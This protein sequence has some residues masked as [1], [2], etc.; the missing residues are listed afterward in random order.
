MADNK[1]KIICEFEEKLLTELVKRYRN[2]KKDAGTNTLNYKTGFDPEKIFPGYHANNTNSQ[3]VAAFNEAAEK[4]QSAGYV[5]L[6]FRPR[7]NEIDEIRLVDARVDD[8]ENYLCEAYG[9]VR[10]SEQMQRARQIVVK[11]GNKTV[12]AAAAECAKIS[13]KL[14][15]NRVPT[16]LDKIE[17]EVRALSFIEEN[18]KEL[19]LRELAGSVFGDSKALDDT[20][21]GK[22]HSDLERVCTTLRKHYNRPCGEDEANI[23]ILEDFHIMAEDTQLCIKGD[24]VIVTDSG[25]IHAGS[26]P[27]GICLFASDFPKIIRIEVN[28]PYFVT[29]ENLTSW[30]RMEKRNM[31]FFY[32]GGFVNRHRREFLKKVY[33]DNPNTQYLHF[34]DIDVGGFRIHADLCRKTGIPFGLYKMSVEEL[35]DERNTGWLH[36]LTD[37]DRAMLEKLLDV[38]EYAQTVW[39]MLQHNVK[40]EQEAVS[41]VECLP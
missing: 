21:K 7:S 13:E 27:G 20:K 29:V 30:R 17:R 14:A 11:Y 35:R 19:F 26:I 38:P 31:V 3:T 2:S 24:V 18:T 34:G 6:S 12:T 9:H 41:L 1:E 36:P 16:N 39:Y 37:N 5:E 8:V 22:N 28:T 23:E 15:K 10:K 25:R 40:L 32:L 33:K 4:C